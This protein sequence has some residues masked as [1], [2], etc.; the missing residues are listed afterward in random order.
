MPGNEDKASEAPLFNYTIASADMRYIEVGERMIYLRDDP[1]KGPIVR[2]EILGCG[3]GCYVDLS[4]IFLEFAMS[5]EGCR[6]QDVA[7]D[8]L[9]YFGERLGKI[10]LARLYPDSSKRQAVDQLIH[11]FDCVYKSMNIPYT[12]DRSEGTLH[13]IFPQCPFCDQE[14]YA[15][16]TRAMDMARLGFI[17]LCECILQNFDSGWLLEKPTKEQISDPLLEVI[18]TSK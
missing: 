3:P 17:A 4:Q 13:Y 6:E 16:F 7:D 14:E 5:C 2:G 1:K 11:V 9:T 8:S 10:L 12:L 18:L 15:G